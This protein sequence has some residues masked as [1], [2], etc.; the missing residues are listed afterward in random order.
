MHSTETNAVIGTQK[1]VYR[2]SPIGK[3]ERDFGNMRVPRQQ[4]FHGDSQACFSVAVHDLS[5]SA[6]EK[7][8]IAGSVSALRHSTAVAAPFT[9]VIS[10]HGR[11]NNVLV[12]AAAFKVLLEAENRHPH[13]FPVAPEQHA[14]RSKRTD[15]RVERAIDYI[16][17]GRRQGLDV[18]T[19]GMFD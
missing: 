17:A 16:S 18:Q 13:D 5:T 4:G 15:R 1:S 11:E 19:F 2:D 3:L 12:E 6:L 10:V 9:G 14:S 8:V 7:R